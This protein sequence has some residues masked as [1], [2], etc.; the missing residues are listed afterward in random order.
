M[1][2]EVSKQNGLLQPIANLDAL[3]DY[4]AKYEQ[5][6]TKIIKKGVDTVSINGKEHIKRSGWRKLATAFGVSDRIT[7]E[8]FDPDSKTWRIW[9]EAYVGEKSCVGIGACSVGEREKAKSQHPEHDAYAIAHT[10]AKNRA[11]SDLLGSGEVSA[12]EM[13]GKTAEIERAFGK[14]RIEA[15][16]AALRAGQK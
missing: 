14:Q 8:Q 5:V 2:I 9:V 1:S 12:E 11:I 6:K 3:A 7:R 15:A 4:F 10:R 13:D 16:D